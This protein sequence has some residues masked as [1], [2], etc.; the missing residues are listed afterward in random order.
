MTYKG[1]RIDTKYGSFREKNLARM[2]VQNRRKSHP[3]MTS[4]WY[5]E[6]ARDEFKSGGYMIA[7]PWRGV[8][9]TTEG[10][11][12]AGARSVYASK[13]VAP[14][15]T[16]SFETGAFRV[17][18]HVPLDRAARALSNLAGGVQT[19]RTR[20]IQIEIVGSAANSRSFPKEYLDG[21]ARLMRW[22]E[23]NTQ[24][25]RTK[26]PRFYGAGEG[27]ILASV[28]SRVRM[29]GDE[30]LRFN[31]WCGHQHV[32]ENNHW[33]PG[34]IDIQYLT[35]YTIGVAPMWDPPIPIQMVATHKDPEN[36]GSWILDKSGAVFAIDGAVFYGTPFGQDYWRNHEA[37]RIYPGSHYSEHPWTQYKYVI[38]ATNGDRYGYG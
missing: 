38:E 27:I 21:L 36:G 31:G 26:Y 13:H 23:N 22:I 29:S 20:C 10:K 11:S 8:L 2:K 15:F 34:N 9:H 16:V 17:W 30:W 19:N 25:D 1:K 24:I 37:A 5:P 33:D 35:N 3:Y 18:Q 12:Y 4:L 14:H 28:S 6:A 32:P 7:T